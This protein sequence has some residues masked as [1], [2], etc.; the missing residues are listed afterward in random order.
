MHATVPGNVLLAASEMEKTAF[1]VFLGKMIRD[2]IRRFRHRYPGQKFRI[3]VAF[4]FYIC[5][6]HRFLMEIAIFANNDV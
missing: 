6:H 2:L 3:G 1:F 4:P 5:P